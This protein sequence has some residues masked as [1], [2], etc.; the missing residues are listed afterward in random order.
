MSMALLWVVKITTPYPPIGMVYED[1][2]LV[3][4]SPMMEYEADI[5]R[6]D[7]VEKAVAIYHN[8]FWYAVGCNDKEYFQELLERTKELR[9]E[10]MRHG[11]K[12]YPCTKKCTGNFVRVWIRGRD[13]M[14]RRYCRKGFDPEKG[15]IKYIRNSRRR[16]MGP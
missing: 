1:G 12:Q 8:R 10:I 16:P 4:L 6:I 9:K 11:P 7:S 13:N 2:N 5:Y 14:P 3:Y 15:S